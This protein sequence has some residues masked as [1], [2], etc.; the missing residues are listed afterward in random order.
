ME[1]WQSAQSICQGEHGNLVSINSGPENSAIKLAFE[2]A[3]ITSLWT[4]GRDA[5]VLNHSFFHA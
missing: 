4:G 5:E 3:G 1:S 2:M